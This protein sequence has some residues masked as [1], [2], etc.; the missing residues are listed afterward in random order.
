MIAGLGMARGSSKQKGGDRLTQFLSG[1]AISPFVSN[2]LQV[3]IESPIRFVTD[4]RQIAHGYEATIL[5]DICDSVLR[6]QDAGVLQKQ[7]EDIA[8]RSGI[9]VSVCQAS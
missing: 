2:K 7:Q 6:A 8:R 9:L 4:D 3:A 1:K 5:V